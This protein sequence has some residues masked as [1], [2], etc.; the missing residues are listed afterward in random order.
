MMKKIFALVLL[1][2][3]GKLSFSQGYPLQQ[4]L[5][6]DSTIVVS[7]G[8]LQSRLVPIVVSDT[9]AANA[10]RIKTYPGAQLY[11]TNGNFYIRNS[12]ATKWVLV[13]SGSSGPV[14]IYNSDGTLTGNRTLTGAGYSLTFNQLS[15]LLFN[16]DSTTINTDQATILNNGVS[17]LSVKGATGRLFLVDT[18][19]P[20]DE[21]IYELK[22]SNGEF[23]ISILNDAQTSN[24]SAFLITSASRVGINTLNPDSTLKVGGGVNI[25]GGLRVGNLPTSPGTKALRI[26][27]NGRLSVA[28]TT[29]GSG[30][31][32]S[33]ATND[34]TGI[35]GGTI[36][37][38]GTLYIDTTIIST[39]AS[40]SGGLAG[41]LNI[42]D[43]S[44]M[45]KDYFNKVGYGLSRS[46]QTILTDSATLSAYYL[47]RKDSLTVTNPLGYVTQKILA[48]T[49]A[50]IRSSDLGGTVTSV[51]TNNGTGIT[52][53]TITTSGTLAIDTLLISTRAWRQKGI[54]SVAA[55]VGSGYVPYMGATQNLD[56]GQFGLKTKYVEFDTSS[57]AVT[58]RRL[59]WSNDEGTLQF[60]M[61][62]GAT[63]TQRIGLEQFAR[64]KNVQGS[65]INKGQA[66]YIY[67]ASGDRASVKLADNRAD[68][69]SSKTLGVAAEDIPINDVGLV[70]TFGQ[71][72]NLNL[73]TFSPGDILYLDSIPGQLTATKP[74]A[75]YHLVFIGVVE[76]ANSGNGLLFVNPQ[77]GYEL[78]E[79]HNVR[80]TSPVP[81]KAILL[82]DS[83]ARLWVDTTVAASGI[84][85]TQV[86]TNSATGITGGPITTTGTIS[87]DTLLLSTRAWRQ[88]GI[89]SVAALINS[90]V[91]GTTNYVSK[92]TGTNTIGNS[93][94][95]DNG[96]NVGIG[97]ASPAS[98]PGYRTLSLNG[99]SGSILDFKTNGTS[100]YQIYGDATRLA[101][102]NLT[103]PGGI[104][105]NQ[106]NGYVGIATTG[107]DSLLTVNGSTHL[108]NAVRMSGLP[109][110]PGTKALRIDASGTISYADTL[111]DAGGTVTSVATNNGT[112]ITGGTITTTGTLAIDT[113]LI[114]TRA[115]RQK[116]VDSVAGLL[117]GYVPTSRTLTINGT[118]YDL[119]A[120][121]SWSV[122]TV[123]SVAT[124]T[125]TGITGGTITSSG[126]IA[127]D[128]LL[129]STRAWR[130]K[131]IDSVAALISSNIS[132]TTNYIPKFTSSSAIGNS[133]IYESSSNIGIGTT[134]PSYK[135]TVNGAIASTS[136]D[137]YATDGTRTNFFGVG[138]SANVGYVGTTT[139][140]ALAFL[141]NNTEQMRLTSTGLGIGTSSPASKLE[142]AGT[143]ANTDFRISRTVSPSTYLY[144][145]A[146]GGS[147]S[148][149]AI[150]INGT[151]V[152][153]L[154]ASGNLGLGVTPSAWGSSNKVYETTFAT[155]MFGR[156]DFSAWGRNAY[157]NSSDA[158]IYANNGYATLYVQTNGQHLWN[159]APS[160]TAGN[161]ISFTQAMTLDAS[162]RLGIGTTSPA[163]KLQL[164]YQ[165][166]DAEVL[167]IGVAYSS[168]NSERGAI[169]WHDGAGYVGKI[170]N[171][172]DGTKTKISIGA[173]YN[174]AYTSGAALTIVGGG[175][176]GIGTTSPT[177]K[178]HVVGGNFDQA[179]LDNTG[180]QYTALDFRNNGTTKTDFYFDNT[181]TLFNIRTRVAAPLIFSTNDSERMRIT[182]GGSLLIGKTARAF[183]TAGIDFQSNG[184][185]CHWTATSSSLVAFNRLSTDGTLI[186]FAQDGTVEGTISISGNTTSYN[187]SS[188][189]RLKQDLKDFNGLSLVNQINVYDY[190]WKSDSTRSYGVMAHEL[191][192]I[193]PYAVTGV[194]DGEKMQGVDYS[195]IVPIL[196]KSIQELKAE[197]ETLKNK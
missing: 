110:A 64:V 195:K 33:V 50:A 150:G 101:I 137:V 26:D 74:Q 4:N 116:G 125:G 57:Q 134:S 117:S 173:L 24:D 58:D 98:T 2:V 90:N 23:F 191:Q 40:V 123:T 177:Y 63:I 176:V 82:Y 29:A 44:N 175:N 48:D 146:P 28:D 112:G 161:A 12:N 196:I 76:R 47:R 94:I 25:V 151:D 67:G 121:R 174:N 139:N 59:Q 66:V 143:S 158:G 41:K 38:S 78:E 45:L 37:T 22:S 193:L 188:D 122:G 27:A 92:F 133:V 164:N 6:N 3:L 113:L 140:H 170:W 165:S 135:L 115:W 88:K 130:Q 51:A 136:G 75:P 128:T 168:L 52:G 55:L 189:Y 132:G 169:A 197:I 107:P 190:Q 53:G 72:G 111:I 187:T 1:L 162:G 106:S 13:S 62:N 31:V 30:T 181:N 144:I 95:F 16:A 124:N 36:T 20:A 126:T 167:R 77:N 118:S 155:S 104:Y 39:V 141:I 9:A 83:V 171:E 97:T 163:T 114:S 138:T 35:K 89:D 152:M 160:G 129:L 73:S 105:L 159:I 87:A 49:A 61:T 153:Y 186:E 11:T 56:L 166:N 46:T 99:T 86:N 54:D 142:V 10:Q 100:R 14:N 172:Y 96:S 145:T 81:N 182:S 184:A 68:S 8:A 71:V 43:T 109:Q 154:N 17:T 79:L 185:D 18:T 127:A 65:Q 157:Y 34:G 21:R 84:A 180:Q 192:S 103:G 42:S 70:G 15:K 102:E 131:G 156:S 183:G 69:T 194:K 32:V 108:K 5:G 179:I 7:K 93:S 149:S 178:L 85:V 80:I 19:A 91:S 147:P 120:N 119:S 148:T 60:G